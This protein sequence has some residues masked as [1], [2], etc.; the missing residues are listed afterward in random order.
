MLI[1]KARAPSDESGIIRSDGKRGIRN[2]KLDEKSAVTLEIT[3]N[4]LTAVIVFISKSSNLRTVILDSIKML[5]PTLKDLG[6]ALI[7]T[8]S[9]K[10]L[11]PSFRRR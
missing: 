8:K 5:P 7:A 1:L 10:I 11:L 6:E 9:G 4:L 2:R 3:D